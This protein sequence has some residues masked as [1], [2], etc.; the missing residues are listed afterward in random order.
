MFFFFFAHF[1]IW[2]IVYLVGLLYFGRGAW[3][4]AP[5]HHS[6]YPRTHYVEQ[7][8]AWR[9]ACLCLLSNRI[10]GLY[11]HALPCFTLNSLLL[12]FESYFMC[13]RYKSEHVVDIR[14]NMSFAEFASEHVACGSHAHNSVFL[15]GL[16]LKYSLNSNLRV[17]QGW[18]DS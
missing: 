12:R 2:F 17:A 10:K 7:A 3:D 15:L 11:R 1:H 13:R 9:F 8:W 4:R 14:M 18:R 6:C 16:F 5:L